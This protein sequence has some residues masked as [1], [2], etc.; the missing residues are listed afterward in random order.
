MYCV[1][2][3]HKSP[4]KLCT[5]IKTKRQAS[6]YNSNKYVYK[7]IH[8]NYIISLILSASF[9]WH[10]TN[11]VSNKDWY[12][13][14]ILVLMN[15][16]FTLYT[17]MSILNCPS[18]PTDDDGVRGVRKWNISIDTLNINLIERIMLYPCIKMS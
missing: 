17:S 14:W 2:Y 13:I 9:S 16:Q 7:C 8:S 1:A 11:L 12:L 10:C 4:V 18:I 15:Y 3:V 5:E 6:L